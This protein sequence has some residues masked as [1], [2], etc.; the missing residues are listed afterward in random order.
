MNVFLWIALKHLNQ[1]TAWQ[2]NKEPDWFSEDIHWR[3]SNRTTGKNC[4]NYGLISGYNF[5]GGIVGLCSTADVT[6]ENCVNVGQVFGM[7]FTCGNLIGFNNNMSIISNCYY[8]NQIN[9]SVGVATNN[10]KAE[11]DNDIDGKFE[12]KPTS[13]IIGTGLQP[14]LG[15]DKWYFENGMYP[16]LKINYNNSAIS[17]QFS[18]ILSETL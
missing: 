7:R 9:T 8:D 18:P 10:N 5:T 12:G 16:R 14:V 4:I 1:G 2:A 15:T 3:S 11:S 17:R 6:T 13:S